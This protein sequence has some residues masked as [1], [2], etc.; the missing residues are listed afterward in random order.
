MVKLPPINQTTH[1][2]R[3]RLCFLWLLYDLLSVIILYARLPIRCS[4]FHS[5]DCCTLQSIGAGFSCYKVRV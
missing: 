2:R 5:Q 3:G 1:C 4:R